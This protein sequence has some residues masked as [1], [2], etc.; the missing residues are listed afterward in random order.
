MERGEGLHPIN[1]PARWPAVRSETTTMI[2]TTMTVMSV[3]RR[4]RYSER[5]AD[6]SARGLRST[7][8]GRSAIPCEYSR[9][10]I[11]NILCT[12]KR[13]TWISASAVSGIWW[14][15]LADIDNVR[16]EVQTDT[17][18]ISSQNQSQTTVTQ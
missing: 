7:V 1:F 8:A 4:R 16:T 13:L 6:S 9:E 11:V 17:Q 14:G 15:H 3:Q 2:T 10:R 12:T 18:I 5:G